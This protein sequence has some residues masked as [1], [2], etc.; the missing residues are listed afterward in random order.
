MKLRKSYRFLRGAVRL[1]TPKMTE[2]WEEPYDGRPAVFCP[3]HARAWGP[4]NMCAHF[5]LAD[6]VRP[7][8]N[9]GIADRKG[10]PD[11]VRNDNWWN[12]K[13]KLAPLFDKTVP[14]LAAAL[15]PPVFNCTPGIPVYY[16]NRVIKTMR[17][18]IDAVKEGDQLVIFA[19]F[20]TEYDT[21]AEQLT[22][23]FLQIAPM[24]WRRCGLQLSFYPVHVDQKNRKIKVLKPILYDPERSLEEQ[25]LLQKVDA[26]VWDD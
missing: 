12:P 15:L 25:Q 1:F 11:Y 9:A 6:S 26:G 3:N 14:Y 19:Q 2:E 18:S 8:Y 23:G 13:S 20:P 4:L 22:G 17:A 5:S 21:H 16:D 10:L 24:C 7:W